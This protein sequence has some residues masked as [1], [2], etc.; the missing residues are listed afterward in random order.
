MH[1]LI[2]P[3]CGYTRQPADTAPESECPRCGIV[4]AKYAEHLARRMAPPPRSPAPDRVDAV[5]NGVAARAGRLRTALWPHP[6]AAEQGHLLPE[7][8]ILLVFALWGLQFIAGGWRHAEPS[9]MHAV[10]LPFHEFGHVLFRPFGQWLM[11]L[12]GSLFQVLLPLLLAGVFLFREGKPF[13]AALCFWW[14]GQSLMDVAPY[15]GDARALAMPLIGEWSEEMV[16]AREFRHDWHNILGAIGLLHWDT[17]LAS[18]AHGL[19]SLVMLGGVGYGA[20]W[21]WYCYRTALREE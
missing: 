18:L 3:K 10:N 7:A 21:L 2:C 4:F 9:F 16:D 8:L 17:R 19:G 14:C 5:A 20:A 11:F 13:G 6:T 12:G 1:R 15:I